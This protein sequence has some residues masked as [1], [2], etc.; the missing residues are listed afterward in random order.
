[1]K[2]LMV[3]KDLLMKGCGTCLPAGRWERHRSV[4]EVQRTA[5]ATAKICNLLTAPK[6]NTLFFF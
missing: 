1:M 4:A 2:V 3:R 5:Q 6:T